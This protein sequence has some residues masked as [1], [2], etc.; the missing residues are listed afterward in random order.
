MA[1]YHLPKLL[2]P[3]INAIFNCPDVDTSPLKKT[4][5]K[6][7]AL[8]DFMVIVPPTYTLLTRYDETK[9]ATLEERCYNA[10]FL[11]DHIIIPSNSNMKSRIKPDNL[12]FH[13]LSGRDIIIRQR[14]NCL[15]TADGFETRQRFNVIKYDTLTSF[16]DYYNQNDSVGYKTFNLIY[17]DQ[18]LMDGTDTTLTY[19]RDLKC[20]DESKRIILNSQTESNPS[21]SNI[22]QQDKS[23]FQCF[24]NTQ[25]EQS[26]RLNNILTEFKETGHRDIETLVSSFNKISNDIY[27][28]MKTENSLRT[29]ENLKKVMREYC[30]LQLYDYV[31]KILATHCYPAAEKSTS[32]S[33]ALSLDQLDTEFYKQTFRMF[34][35]SDIVQLEKNI[36]QAT[37]VFTK[38]SVSNSYS[39]KSKILIETLQL[40]SKPIKRSVNVEIPI[41]ADTLM[42]LFVHI[43][44]RLNSNNLKCHLYYLQHFC[45][46]ENDI[47]FGLL[48][49]ALSTLEA[50]TVYMDSLN[51]DTTKH[52]LMEKKEK[53]TIQ[54]IEF[55]TASNNL[56]TNSRISDFS[57]HFRY[58]SETGQSILSICIV[59]FQNNIIIDLLSNKEFEKFF[60][61]DD[62]LDDETVDGSTLLIQA[63]KYS[64]S[65]VASILVDIILANCTEDEIVSYLKRTNDEGR[66]AAHFLNDQVELLQK[67]GKYV[68]WDAR[69]CT[70]QTPLFT[71]FRSYDQINYDLMVS[72]SLQ[73][74]DHWYR[75]IK[76][77]P[78]DLGDH[79]DLKGNTLLHI[80]K[81]NLA[82]LLATVHKIDVNKCNKKGLTP[83]MVFVKY[84]RFQNVETIL[85]DSRIIFNK[86]KDH[87][88]LDCFDYAQNERI[89]ELLGKHA[90]ENKTVFH[91]MY[92]HSLKFHQNTSYS[93]KI[94][95]RIPG[96]GSSDTYKTFS[97][98]LKTIR[99]LFRVI[100]KSCPLTFLPLNGVLS[101]LDNMSSIFQ[102]KNLKSIR[103][104][105]KEVILSWL[106]QCLDTLVQMK[107]LPISDILNDSISLIEWI[108]EQKTELKETEK[109]NRISYQR[110]SLEPEQV[111][112]IQNFLKFNLDELDSI[113]SKLAA[114]KKLVIFLKLKKMDI[115]E[116]KELLRILSHDFHRKS[117]SKILMKYSDIKITPYSR[118]SIDSL[119]QSLEFIEVCTVK[120]SQQITRLLNVDIPAWWRL[121]GELLEL[122]RYDSQ[123][124]ASNFTEETRINN[125]GGNILTNFI[126]SKKLKNERQLYEHKLEIKR[127]LQRESLNINIKH[128]QQAEELSKFVLFKSEYFTLGLVKMWSKQN[129]RSLKQIALS[130]EAKQTSYQDHLLVV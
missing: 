50:V 2:N 21:Q 111:N 119:L 28:L 103:L 114:M 113:T 62:L 115:S 66:N 32:F 30:E 34:R 67:I 120:L 105:D 107:V 98:N 93:L 23:L 96:A 63:L 58:R 95:V 45:E 39:Q 106:T 75:T 82:T 60:P 19:T 29:I 100:L 31:W 122:N 84:N 15:Y 74:S 64:N 87:N 97:L 38:L 8:N 121:Y 108:Q 116:S 44:G 54:C 53:A 124:S 90:L 51:N 65:E 70:N 12:L 126:E 110:D 5:I 35:L 91:H 42:S 36:A 77:K 9:K 69:D 59:N 37:R 61:L 22:Y 46:N 26:R 83:L 72:I 24:L 79:V 3:L 10:D 88:G 1:D 80:I 99:N 16:N 55:I 56:G 18:P 102:Q 33:H 43:M 125:N 71:I 57:D 101:K 128:E 117:I 127:L 94:S 4:Y 104:R 112:I 11:S 25:P 85:K 129:I 41:S 40:L 20:F 73:L 17:I 27:N 78:L 89:V 48:G 86:T 81:S 13:T 14:N 76:H 123:T 68:E 47:K 7:K 109:K 130:L 118:D 52:D 49:Y 6:L 92:A